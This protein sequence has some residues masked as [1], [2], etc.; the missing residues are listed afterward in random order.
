MEPPFPGMDPYLEAPS[1][2]PDVHTSLIYAIREQIQRRLGPRYKAVITPY[3]SLESVDIVPNRRSIMSDLGVLDRGQIS[4]HAASSAVVAPAPLTFTAT[5]NMPTR[6]ARLEIRLLTE[7]TLVTAVELLSPTNKRPGVDG[8]DAYERKRQGIFRSDAH[9]LE[10]DLLRGG[11]RPRLDQPLPPNPYFVLL[12]RATNRPFIE[13]WPLSLRNAPPPTPVPLL[14]PDDDI[15]L[16][17]GAAIRQIYVSARYER[18]I[19]YRAAPPP[20]ELSPED[21]AWLDAHLRER[22]LR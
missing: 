1:L 22:G 10:L 14:P 21:A 19:D 9:L 12:S 7:D 20:P 13:V 15:P 6:L 11:Q 3:I 18:Q 4:D 16:D 17:L 2:W 5:I 8:A